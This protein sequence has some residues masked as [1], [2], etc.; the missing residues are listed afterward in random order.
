MDP[1]NAATLGIKGS[2]LR[3]LRRPPSYAENRLLGCCQATLILRELAE[4]PCPGARPSD[5]MLNLSRLAQAQ[6][7]SSPSRTAS[8]AW[9]SSWGDGRTAAR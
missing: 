6:P 4:L 2:S 3:S 9:R 5:F 8:A 7:R 1:C